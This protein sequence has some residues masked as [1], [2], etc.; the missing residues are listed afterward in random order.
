MKQ[1]RHINC[2]YHHLSTISVSSGMYHH[3]STISVSSGM[4]YHLSTISVSSGMYHHLSTISVSSGMYH[5][6]NYWY[7][8]TQS[9]RSNLVTAL[10]AQYSL[11]C[12]NIT[13]FK[14]NFNHLSFIH[15]QWGLKTRSYYNRWVIC[16]RS[17]DHY[18]YHPALGVFWTICFNHYCSKHP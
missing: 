3:L 1:V 7:G 18:L 12:L 10:T 14:N 15:L 17:C 8:S 4:Y 11:H 6:C 2:M 5:H 9:S 16:G 13:V